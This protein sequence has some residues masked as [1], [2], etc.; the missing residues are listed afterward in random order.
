MREISIAAISSLITLTLSIAGHADDRESFEAFPSSNGEIASNIYF[1]QDGVYFI[2]TDLSA[3]IQAIRYKRFFFSVDLNEETYMGRKYHSNMVFDP[4]RGGW[5]FGISGRLEFKRYFVE[6]QMHHNCF[7]DIGRW[8]SIDYSVYWNT[9][10]LGFGSINFLPQNKYH[11][12]NAAKT[13]A[14]L[15]NKMDYIIL[16][17][18]FAPRGEVWQKNHDQEFALETNLFYQLLRFRQFGLNIESNNLWVINAA[19]DLKRKHALDFDLTIYGK[20][21]VIMAYIGWWPY[22]SQSIRNRD[23]K[24]VFGMRLGF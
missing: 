16:A 11:Q 3:S 10:R 5:S 23:G 24:T 21:G 2:D 8:M 19:H 9:P 4:N 14:Y 22:D 6:A 7:H 20:H 17:G 15:P 18:F 12:P 13:D 1:H